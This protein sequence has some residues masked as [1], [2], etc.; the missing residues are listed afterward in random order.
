MTMTDPVADMLTRIRN[1]NS[2]GH[3]DVSVPASRMKRS[4]A[5]ILKD[6]GY[7]DDF[8]LVEDD[9]QGMIS[10]KMKYGVD[11]EKVISGIRKISKPGLRVYAKA[12]D[13]PRVLGGL[14]IA[15]ISTSKGV[16]SD[17]EA[18]RLGVGGEVVCYVW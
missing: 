11:N 13:V 9:K 6:E 7:I 3:E 5:G 17:K 12:E 4:I 1:A 15:I 18:R 14:G 16:I 8:K 10:I 2:V